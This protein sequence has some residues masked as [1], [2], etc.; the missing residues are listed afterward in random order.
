MPG[1]NALSLPGNAMDD[2]H[3]D[4]IGVTSAIMETVPSMLAYWDRDLICGYAN[5]A[6]E[7]WFGISGE[8]LIGTS[9][10]DLLGPELFAANEPHIRAALRGNV[11]EFERLVP[12]P[13]GTRPSLAVYTPHVVEGEVLGFV[14]QVTD[15]TLLHRTRGLLDQK[16]HELSHTNSLL[17]KSK[18]ELK[19]AQRI[20]EMGSWYWE[21]DDDIVSWS[22]QLYVL[23]GLDETRQPPKFSEHEALYTPQSFVLVEKAVKAAILFGLPYNIEVEYVH[24]TGRRGWLEVRGTAEYDETGRVVKLHGTAL[25]ITAR[26]LARESLGLVERVALLEARLAD[27]KAK[28]MHLEKAA[29]EAN[30]LGA[31]GLISSGIAHD[32]N[33]VLNS[34]SVIV[35]LL[36]RTSGEPKTIQLAG[37]GRQAIGRAGSLTRRLMNVARPH[38]PVS[39]VVKLAPVLSASQEVFKLA[40]GALNQMKFD[41]TLDVEVLLNVH[42]LEIAVLNLVINARDAMP[43]AGCIRVSL[44]EAD[45]PAGCDEQQP[46]RWVALAVADTGKGMDT[47]TLRLACEPFYTTK[48]SERGTGLGLAMV[49]AFAIASGGRLLLDSTPGVGTTVRIVFPALCSTSA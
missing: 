21:I 24:R 10:R 4:H 35:Q 26:R 15:V 5:K 13:H 25:E 20:G 29:V 11:Q 27:E 22:N 9:M 42:E 43:A 41:V 2:L 38:E 17:R 6:Y 40:A 12:G 37:Q 16:V 18:A 49:N 31:V 44:E 48:G 1:K 36:E 34:L 14:A 7:K 39:S 23:F 32:F 19:L 33:N 46:S 3:T 47:E 30:R 8:L 45:A 28:N